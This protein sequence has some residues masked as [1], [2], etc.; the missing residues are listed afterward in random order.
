[1]GPTG[2]LRRAKPSFRAF[3]ERVQHGVV[4]ERGREM[5]LFCLCVF[6]AERCAA[7]MACCRR[8]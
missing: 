4:L 3:L 7:V 6:A 1:M 5:M 2:G 8:R